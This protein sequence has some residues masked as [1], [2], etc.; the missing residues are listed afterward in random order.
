MSI[1]N[2]STI[3]FNIIFDQTSFNKLTGIGIPE[4]LLNLVTC[5]GFKKK[6]NSTV[7]LNCLYLLVNNYLSKVLFMIEKDSKKLS[8]LPNGVKF[9][10]FVIDRLETDF[11]MAKNKAISSVTNTIIKFIC[12]V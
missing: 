12:S 2:L 9:R 1:K 5:H 8:I 3:S 10:I 6:P 4:L 7:I 11:V